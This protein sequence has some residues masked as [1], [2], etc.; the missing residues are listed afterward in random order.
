MLFEDASHQ[1]SVI[2]QNRFYIR[3]EQLKT[4]NTIAKDR[5]RQVNAE[6]SIAVFYRSLIFYY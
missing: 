5:F 2:K 1:L 3:T 4:Y 6:G